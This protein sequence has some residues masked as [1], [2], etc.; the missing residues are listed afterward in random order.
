ML[1]MNTTLLIGFARFAFTFFFLVKQIWGRGR[2]GRRHVLWPVFKLLVARFNEM[3]M[4]LFFC[5]EVV[6]F[7]IFRSFYPFLIGH[8]LMLFSYP[9][10]SVSSSFRCSVLSFS[11]LCWLAIIEHFWYSILKCQHLVVFHSKMLHLFIPTDLPE[12]QK[13]IRLYTNS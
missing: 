9:F 12:K 4:P 11:I 10:L 5:F 7:K 8:L 13:L 2:G 1:K 3:V 6:P